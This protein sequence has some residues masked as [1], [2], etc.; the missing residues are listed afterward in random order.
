MLDWEIVS[1]Y[2]S[3][4]SLGSAVISARWC[5]GGAESAH[6][7]FLCVRLQMSEN[8]KKPVCLCEVV[9]LYSPSL[10]KK[11]TVLNITA[12]SSA[13]SSFCCQKSVS[14]E[15]GRAMWQVTT[16]MKMLRSMVVTAQ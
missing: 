2:L 9:S 3:P 6:L 12:T 15:G 14:D 1:M 8:W 11:E 7:T 5:S 4:F 16:L 10:G 13:Y